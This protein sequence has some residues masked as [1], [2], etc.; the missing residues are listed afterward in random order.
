MFVKKN[1]SLNVGMRVVQYNN[2]G[3]GET[4]PGVPYTLNFSIGYSWWK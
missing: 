2:A 4:N 1:Q 3:L